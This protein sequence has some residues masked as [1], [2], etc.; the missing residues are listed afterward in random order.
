M[1]LMRWVDGERKSRKVKG[2]CSHVWRTRDLTFALSGTRCEVCERCGM[3]QVTETDE[4]G[5]AGSELARRQWVAAAR[6]HGAGLHGLTADSDR[7]RALH[8][9][10][11]AP[12]GWPHVTRFLGRE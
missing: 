11:R 8:R 7:G 4:P 3:L 6:G 1:R 12:L 5:A 9:G 2:A 10:Q